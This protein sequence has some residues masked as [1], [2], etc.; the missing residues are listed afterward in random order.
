MSEEEFPWLEYDDYFHF[1]PPE[2][3]DDEVVGAGGNLSPG[4]LISAYAQGIFPW[5][6]EGEEILWWSLDPRFILYPE[7]LRVS[8]SMKKILKSGRFTVTVDRCFRDVMESCGKAPRREQDG[9]WISNDMIDA[10]LRLHDLGFAHSVEVWEN[11]ELAGGLYGV[12]LG[13]AFFGESMFAAVPNSSKTA[14]I[15]LTSFLQDKKFAFI[16]CQQHTDH[17]GSLGAADVPRS[18]FITELK[19][20][21]LTPTVRGSW[22]VL[23]PDF[24]E[25]ELWNSLTPPVLE[26][27]S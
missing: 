16:D 7:N 17:L 15:A 5:F 22:S 24:P 20:V 25:S 21:L 3:W 19:D 11:D 23:F 10:Y 18:R 4:L 6:N 2:S 12:S 8:K 13:R 14:L 9:S 26:V 1:P 27:G